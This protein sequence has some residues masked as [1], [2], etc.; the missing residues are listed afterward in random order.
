[1]D[2]FYHLVKQG[3]SIAQAAR[4]VG[5]SPRW[6]YDKVR[7]IDLAVKREEEELPDPIAYADLDGGVKDTLQDFLLF[8]KVFLAR[9]EQVWARDAAD[10]T[11]EWL[12]NPERR[13]FAVANIFPGAGKALALDTPLP[14]PTGWT[15][16]KDVA[17]GDCL[18]DENGQPC[19]VTFKSEVF[20]DHDCYEVRASDGVSVVADAD[21]LWQARLNGSI[22]Q[23]PHRPGVTGPK[24]RL[25]SNGR[26]V[27]KTSDLFTTRTKKRRGENGTKRAQLQISEPLQLPDKDLPIDPYVLGLWLGDGA[28]A[29]GRISVG[30][31]DKDAILKLLRERGCSLTASRQNGAVWTIRVAGLTR[32]LRQNN[33]LGNK[34][35]PEPYLRGSIAQRRALLQ[36]FV[37]SD[38]HVSPKGRVEFTS[39]NKRLARAVQEL[40]HSLGVKASLREGRA[41]LNG[42]DCG[43]KYRVGFYYEEAARLPRKKELCR[44]GLRT[45]HRYLS[46]APVE[47]VP[48]QCIQ[49]DSPSHLYLAGEGMMVTHNTTAWTHDLIVWLIAGGGF[50]SPASGRALRIMIGSESK[51]VS[52][53]CVRRIRN[54]LD[55]RRPFFDKENQ[56]HAELVLSE[57]FGRFRPQASRGD[58]SLWRADQFLVAQMMDLDLYEKEPT[59]Q[60]VSKEAGFLGERCN[61]AVWDDLVTKSNSKNA[62]IAASLYDWWTTEAETRVEPGGVLMLVGQRIGNLD[63]YRQCLDATWVDSHGETQRKYHHIVYPAHLEHI[64]PTGGSVSEKC[65][66]WDGKEAGCLL[67]S[68]RLPWTDL[69]EVSSKHN[70]RTVWL[71]EDANPDDL[72]VQAP[73][74]YGGRDADGWEAPGCLDHKR[75]FWEIEEGNYVVYA[76]VDPSV[77]NFWAIEVWAYD[78]ASQKRHLLYGTH[79]RMRAGLEKGFLDWDHEKGDAVGLMEELQRVS[80]GIG[81]AIQ[82]WVIEANIGKYLFQTNAFQRWRQ[83]YPRVDVIPHLTHQHNKNDAEYGVDALLGM[84]YKVGL[85]RLPYGP[86]TEVKQYV[87]AKIQELTK[88]P[89]YPTTDTVMADWF[90]EHN[91]KRITYLARNRTPSKQTVQ[92]PPGMPPYLIAQQGSMAVR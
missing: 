67:D 19:R 58:D 76:C 69:Q 2:Q 59:V 6:G 85:K 92:H 60:A 89:Q 46:V 81:H 11:V 62:E 5:M 13:D 86:G 30:E 56:R 12:L 18:F 66:Q 43:P 84:V 68:T 20:Y 77:S 74:I 91:L 87:K 61:L 27:Y 25:D 42:K 14:T 71:Q 21:H 16:M 65:V 35:V 45:P 78:E 10:R 73:W 72:L 64:C 49:V 3:F 9:D 52:V 23:T 83:K 48:T 33:L 26:G 80:I 1:M 41:S 57:A 37:D 4:A 75:A 82:V 51:K 24:T 38:G 28:S 31:K 90:G 34:H 70:Y 17:V 47:S 15:T 54:T 55:L 53:N 50:L 29:S 8:R 40:A 32:L 7:G 63:L 44:K 36:G 88:Y 79:R 22:T 39:I